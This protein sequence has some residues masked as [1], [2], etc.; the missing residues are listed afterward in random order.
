MMREFHGVAVVL[1]QAYVSS[2]PQITGRV[3]VN[4]I[5][6]DTVKRPAR[7][8]GWIIPN[9]YESLLLAIEFDHTL[10]RANPQPSS[11]ILKDGIGCK[12][13]NRLTRVQ[14]PIGCGGTVKYTQSKS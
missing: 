1:A 2:E 12:F 11:A 5:D 14:V 13:V 6:P 7:G 9:I 3:F 10:S 4:E 8:D